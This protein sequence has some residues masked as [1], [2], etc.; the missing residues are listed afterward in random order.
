MKLIKYGEKYLIFGSMNK[1]EKI[2]FYFNSVSVAVCLFFIFYL[3][4]I[5]SQ[6][7]LWIFGIAA[8]IFAIN[9]FFVFR[10]NK[11]LSIFIFALTSNFMMLLF[12]NGY[13]NSVK[14]YAF[15]FPLLLSNFLITRPDHRKERI[16]I[17]A[18]T[19]LCLYLTNFT[20][21]TPRLGILLYRQEHTDVLSLINLLIGLVS[22]TIIL[23]I[24]S[25]VN[26]KTESELLQKQAD[27]NKAEERWNFALSN[28][29]EGVFDYNIATG[30]VYFSPQW[31]KM[32][33]YDETTLFNSLADWDNHIHPD[34]LANAKELVQKHFDGETEYY[35]NVI[36]M[37]CKDDSYKWIYSKGKV[38]SFDNNGKALRFIGTHTDITEQ[39][40][41]QDEL[42]NSQQLL[43]SIN[44][45]ITEGIYRS[46]RE[47]RLIYVNNAFAVT[48]GYASV[49]DVLKS[50][51][52]FDYLDSG[53][54]NSLLDKINFSGSFTNEEVQFRKKD[55]TIFWCLISCRLTTNTN[56]NSYYDGAIRDISRIKEIEKE[57]IIAKNIAEKASLAK[58]DFLSSMSHEI[59]TPMNSVIGISNLLIRD[60]PRPDQMENLN[61]LKFSA[62]N[63]MGLINNI[64]DFN[65]IESGKIEL[66][67]I[68]VNIDHLVR[69]IVQTHLSE[70]RQKDITLQLDSSVSG[71]FLTDPLRLSQIMNNLIS[72][73]IKFTEKGI[74]KVNVELVNYTF[75]GARLKFIVKD[76][77]IG[78]DSENI[79]MVFEQFS[80]ENKDITRRFGGTGL[81]LAITKKLLELM[82]GKIEA[83][84]EKG[85]GSTFSFELELM[86]NP[87]SSPLFDKKKNKQ[88]GR[89]LEG[90]RILL[91]EDHQMNI[92]LIKKFFSKWG[93]SLDITLNGK[94]AIVMAKNNKYELIL[95][96]L[97]MPKM[98]GYQATREIRKFDTA[99]PVF[100]ITADVF[101]ET[102][103]KAIACGMNDF[104]SKPFDPDELYTKIMAIRK[105]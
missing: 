44:Q 77:G 60:N 9:N 74:V 36:R 30:E 39:K 76:S 82:N 100:A 81:G 41:S 8:C 18:F 103:T 98:D 29:Q 1:Q 6:P 28:N 31:K 20:T 97:H 99:V 46:E 91:V 25:E 70:A 52:V 68:P 78:I 54:R 26:Y 93:V 55:G 17:L 104:V 86:K 51:L 66:E 71:A 12:D 24:I 92:L 80:Q 56:G 2:L 72:N 62:E 34:D 50:E 85:K 27:I 102:K 5:L 59:R 47:G 87:A 63:L 38:R 75:E 37:R 22:A 58:S 69:S 90:M 16:L 11:S 57:L 10:K 43:S 65:K 14:T 33:G 94:E 32:L 48:F 35:E 95:M 4:P 15:Y 83:Q 88:T 7:Y 105:R 49:D 45:N 23:F 42:V 61:V 89:E 3:Y 53:V 96:D 21:L 101:T 73:A 40:K 79:S 84:S 67:M 13:T 19:F 64:L